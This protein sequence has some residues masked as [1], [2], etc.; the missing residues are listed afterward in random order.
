MTGRTTA[1]AALLAV[2]PFSVNAGSVTGSATIFLD[3]LTI[4]QV[5]DEGPMPGMGPTPPSELVSVTLIENTLVTAALAI[6]P[7]GAEYSDTSLDAGSTAATPGGTAT[8]TADQVLDTLGTLSTTTEG[9]ASGNAVQYKNFTLE[10]LTDW[11]Y[12]GFLEISVEYAMSV[13]DDDPANPNVPLVDVFTEV[14]LEAFLFDGALVD[15]ASDADAHVAA[16][17][18]GFGLFEPTGTLHAIIPLSPLPMGSFANLSIET[19][20]QSFATAVPVPPA[21]PLLTSAIAALSLLRRRAGQ[22]RANCP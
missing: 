10:Y 7:G 2:L 16:N 18:F 22:F 4:T 20:V 11:D 1:L 19:T 21:L 17:V 15:S 8:A 9:T 12:G 13:V 6:E 5:V 14:G 3:T